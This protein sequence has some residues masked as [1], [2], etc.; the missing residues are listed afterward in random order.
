MFLCA[1]VA[2]VKLKG[3]AEKVSSYV[4]SAHIILSESAKISFFAVRGTCRC[5]N[6]EHGGSLGFSLCFP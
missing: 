2:C 1:E 4:S 5:L 6:V 3:K